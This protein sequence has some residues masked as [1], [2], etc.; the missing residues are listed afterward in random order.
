LVSNDGWV[1]NYPTPSLGNNFNSD[2]AC[3][4]ALEFEYDNLNKNLAAPDIP[5]ANSLPSRRN[6]SDPLKGGCS[7]YLARDSYWRW[8]D[9]DLPDGFPFKSNDINKIGTFTFWWQPL[10]FSIWGGSFRCLPSLPKYALRMKTWAHR[11]FLF[12]TGQKDYGK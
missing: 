4:M 11:F 5:F 2:P 1:D 10:N 6:V 12:T 8:N 9:G 7:S 3:L